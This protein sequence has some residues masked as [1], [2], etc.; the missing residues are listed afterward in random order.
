MKG[1]SHAMAIFYG[2]GDID[3]LHWTTS[4][5]VVPVSLTIPESSWLC[6]GVMSHPRPCVPYF[7][8]RC[9]LR[10]RFPSSS[11]SWNIVAGCR[12]GLMCQDVKSCGHLSKTLECTGTSYVGIEG[13]LCDGR[14]FCSV[15][16]FLFAKLTGL[17]L[18]TDC[19]PDVDKR[20]SGGLHSKLLPHS[21]FFGHPYQCIRI[22]RNTW[23]SRDNFLSGN[24]VVAFSRGRNEGWILTDVLIQT[25]LWPPKASTT[26]LVGL[27]W[28]RMI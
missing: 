4:H 22:P 14:R 15:P 26:E 24:Y 8:R 5:A 13:Y 18:L 11:F 21:F 16:P 23:L 3:H 27:V 20:T 1:F 17:F 7:C 10:L 9:S 2:S 6:S 19:F 25:I 28:A 12:L